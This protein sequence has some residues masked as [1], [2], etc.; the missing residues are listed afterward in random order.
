MGRGRSGVNSH[1]NTSGLEE[2]KGDPPLGSLPKRDYLMKVGMA[3][4]LS[5]PDGSLKHITLYHGSFQDFEEFDYA[6]GKSVKGG[7]MD[8]YGQGFYF[9]SD[10]AKAALFG[11][12]IYT[13]DVAYSTSRR[14]AK[15]TGREADFSYNPETGYWVIPPDKSGNLRIKRKKALR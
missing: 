6:K 2:V 11:D 3:D 8:Q 9:T 14:V 10:P 5:S 7:G 1:P 4:G 13:V 12:I 15:R